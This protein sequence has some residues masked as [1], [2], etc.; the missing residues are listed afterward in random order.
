MRG[1]LA[2]LGWGAMPDETPVPVGKQLLGLAKLLGAAA[3]DLKTVAASLVALS[4]QLT[5][6]G[7]VLPDGPFVDVRADIPTNPG[8]V[9]PVAWWERDLAQISGITIH[10]TGASDPTTAAAWCIHKGRPSIQYHFFIRYDGVALYTAD[11]AWGLWHDHTG[12]QNLNISVGLAGY[13][14]HAPPPE[15]MLTGAARLCAWLM[16]AH[17]IDQARVLGHCDHYNTIC[18]GWDAASWRGLFFEKL[19]GALQ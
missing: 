2:A 6:H 17:N 1:W 19:A 15:A 14:H 11:L 7:V 12:G 16:D 4:E 10:H 8:P 5:D 13:H 18:P 9:A 3:D